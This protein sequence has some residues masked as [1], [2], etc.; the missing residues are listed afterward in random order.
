M[1]SYR[2]FF[3]GSVLID[4]P[5]AAQAAKQAKKYRMIGSAIEASRPSR[6]DRDVMICERGEI[7]L[8]MGVPCRVCRHNGS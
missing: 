2:V 6:K 3:S 8:K 5:N 1:P 4:A 7:H